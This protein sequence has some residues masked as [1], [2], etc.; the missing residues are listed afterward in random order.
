[1]KTTSY[2]LKKYNKS[3]PS[4]VL[5]LHATHFRFDDQDGS[6]SY[7]SPMRVLLEH[8]KEQTVPHDMLDELIGA[9]I[10]FYESKSHVIVLNT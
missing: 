3:P 6:F 2:I 7:S 8:I 9:G 10:K 1:M 4:F 5:H